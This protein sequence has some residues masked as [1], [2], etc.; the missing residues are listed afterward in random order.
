MKTVGLRDD[1][2]LNTPQSQL[3]QSPVILEENIETTRWIALHK[4]LLDQNVPNFWDG[5]IYIYIYMP[6]SY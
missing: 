3:Q 1:V 4:P 6:G 2:S 5:Y